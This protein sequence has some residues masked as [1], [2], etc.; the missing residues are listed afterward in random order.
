[1]K[2]RGNNVVPTSKNDDAFWLISTA[3]FDRYLATESMRPKQF[4]VVLFAKAA[5]SRHFE[6]CWMG[7]AE[8]R[9]AAYF[10]HDALRVILEA[11]M[12]SIARQ[13][14]EATRYT[15]TWHAISK[16]VKLQHT[17][18]HFNHL[19]PKAQ[20]KKMH[21]FG[22]VQ[23]LKNVGKRHTRISNNH[24]ILLHV[25]FSKQTSCIINESAA[26]NC[27]WPPRC[28]HSWYFI[29]T[30]PSQFPPS[31]F[32]PLRIWELYELVMY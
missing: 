12:Q 5:I 10:F 6:A 29:C 26:W 27:C 8:N 7:S 11:R 31:K 1:M 22:T 30:P 14:L 19:Q 21:P 13:H 28:I 24:W 23:S 3:A 20:P 9:T 4:P 18:A 16:P 25:V 15:W 17:S 2:V 32:P